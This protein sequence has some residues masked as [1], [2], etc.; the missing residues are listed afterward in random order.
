MHS[1]IACGIGIFFIALFVYGTWVN[2]CASRWCQV[3]G[4]PISGLFAIA[5]YRAFE[6]ARN[7]TIFSII[8]GILS[9]AS[10]ILMVLWLPAPALEQQDSL[11]GSGPQ[12]ATSEGMSGLFDL[13]KALEA[14]MEFAR[15]EAA[16][17]KLI[18]IN[19]Y[20]PDVH[21]SYAA[22]LEKMGK[23]KKAI[24]HLELAI[25]YYEPESP[26]REEALRALRILSNEQGP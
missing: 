25:L 19:K 14:S 15:S 5:A 22:L 18:G 16:Y 10:I 4:L 2:L 1:K 11:K 9:L 21:F 3:L 26:Y 13:A 12:Y 7:Q 8:T 20:N 24:H 17:E 6:K 23:R